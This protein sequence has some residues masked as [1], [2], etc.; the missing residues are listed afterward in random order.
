MITREEWT[1]LLE[2]RHGK[3]LQRKFAAATVAVCGLG[4]LGSNIAVS[5]ARAGVGKLILADFDR[6]DAANLQR[7]Q[8]RVSQT[9]ML[10]TDAVREILADIAPYAEVETHAVRLTAENAAE[11]LRGADVVCEAFDSPESKAE[12]ADAVLSSLPGSRLVAASGMAG[13]GSAN[14]VRTRRITGR[15]YLCGDGE[16]EAGENE[17]MLS[18][19]VM[20]CAAHQAHATLRLLAGL[21]DE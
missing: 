4:G 13:T 20:L 15:F 21:Y 12:L 10:K 14:A 16:S 3:D 9:G 17:C 7:Q 19:R 2:K 6:V 5:L 1:A 8:Y 11:L 18:S